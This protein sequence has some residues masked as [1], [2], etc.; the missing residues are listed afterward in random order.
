MT[1]SSKNNVSMFVRY[2]SLKKRK[3]RVRL[4]RREDRRREGLKEG[5]KREG[6]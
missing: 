2:S 1:D 6:R 3:G 5:R 4:E